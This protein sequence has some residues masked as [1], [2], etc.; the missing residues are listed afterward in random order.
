MKRP[1]K[2]RSTP[3]HHTR[4]VKQDFS[5][6]QLAA[7]GAATL[8]FNELQSTIE[9]MLQVATGIPKWLF[10]EVGSRINGLEGKIA[11]IKMVLDNAISE[12]KELNEIKHSVGTFFEFKGYRDAIIHAR[13][14]N[15]ALGIG[16]SSERRAQESEVLLRAEDLDT[17]YDHIIALQKEIFSASELLASILALKALASDDQ[18]KA[19]FEEAIRDRRTQFRESRNRRQ[20]LKPMPRF[21]TESELQEVESRWIASRSATQQDWYTPWTMPQRPQQMSS[22]LHL[23]QTPLVLRLSQDE[24]S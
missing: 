22:D 7:V 11:I 4:D 18:N 21:P 15:A 6:D 19:P 2:G 17:F 24:S 16:L 12:P 9:A 3:S 1:A 8:A 5:R 14:L 20:S 23:A 10:S 13:V